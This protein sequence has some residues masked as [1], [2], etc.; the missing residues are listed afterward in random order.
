MTLDEFRA[1]LA[2]MD[3]RCGFEIGMFNWGA[4][5]L[6]PNKFAYVFDALMTC[7]V[8]LGADGS[9]REEIEGCEKVYP[10]AESWK[11]SVV[12]LVLRDYAA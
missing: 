5:E 10:S 12:E 3:E 11:S 1:H 8:T 4:R 7:T 6:G 9:V 2:N